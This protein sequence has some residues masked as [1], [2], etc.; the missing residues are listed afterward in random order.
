VATHVVVY[1]VLFLAGATM[2]GWLLANLGYLVATVGTLLASAILANWLSLRIFETRHLVD[3]G[4]W[5]NRASGENLA[6]GFAGG[7]GAAALVL[8]PPLLLR[9]AHLV[10]TPATQATLGSFAFVTVVLAAGAFAEEL[11]FRGYGFQLLLSAAGPYAT[12][13]PVG[14][15]F[16]LMH[17]SNPNV[18]WTGLANTAGFGIL[19]GYAYLRSRD[20]WLPVGLHF[21]WNFTLP[22]FGVN[23]SG[24]RMRETD[25]E[26]AWSAGP[27]WSGGA[28]GPEASL[29]TSVVVFLLFVYIWKAPVRRQFS[30][31]TDPPVESAACEPTRPLPS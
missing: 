1:A 6:I 3:A 4:L 15:L 5:W 30:P 14:V 27:A 20:L 28:Y 10:S 29:L 31:I 12:I 9:A 11:L 24:L 17:G 19:F 8:A 2:F 7:T 25:Y 21:G 23:L 22:L 16:A 26:M 13:L 18:T